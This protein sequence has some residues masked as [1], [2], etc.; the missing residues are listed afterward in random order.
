MQSG[1]VALHLHLATGAAPCHLT[2]GEFYCPFGV[3]L[4]VSVWQKAHATFKDLFSNEL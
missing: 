3:S 4:N 1:L 2:K